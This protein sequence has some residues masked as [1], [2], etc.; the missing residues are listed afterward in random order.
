MRSMMTHPDTERD[1]RSRCIADR[2]R[3]HVN[4]RGLDIDDL[5][6]LR[7]H[8]LRSGLVNDG[9]LLINNWRS[10][11]DHDRSRCYYGSR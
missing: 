7:I 5:R 10:R 8:D 6:R 11:L 9:R 4:G 3:T 1:Y 2:S